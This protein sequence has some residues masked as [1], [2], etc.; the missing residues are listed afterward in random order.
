[1]EE[2]KKEQTRLAR[3]LRHLRMQGKI[4][5]DK[6]FADKVGTTATTVSRNKNSG[7]PFDEKIMRGVYKA[8][9]DIINIDYLRGES[10]IM[11]V[12]DLP[13][14]KDA[15]A[16]P[17]ETTPLHP[18]CNGLISV[19][20][21]AKDEVIDTLKR[22]LAGTIAAKDETIAVQKCELAA[23]DEI[24]ATKDAL[25]KNLQQTVS[26]LRADLSMEKGLSTG[27]SLSAPADTNPRPRKNV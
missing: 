27:T 25:I 20:L 5:S 17:Q 3:V 2:K 23:K 22:Q 8:F 6:D 4:S 11:L 21:A 26:S 7:N 14:G 18:D 10:D 16:N 24:I 1:M 13:S 12:K 9:G 15:N 19:A